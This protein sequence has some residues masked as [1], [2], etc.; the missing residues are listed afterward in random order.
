MC[1]EAVSKEECVCVGGGG[2]TR[3]KGRSKVCG[4]EG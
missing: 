2:L 1:C 4:A 3:N